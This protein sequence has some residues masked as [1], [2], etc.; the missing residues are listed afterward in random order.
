MSLFASGYE[1]K[2][3]VTSLTQMESDMLSQKPL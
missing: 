2:V 3:H 1:T